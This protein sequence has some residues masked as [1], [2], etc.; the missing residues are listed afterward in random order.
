MRAS[1]PEL[2]PLHTPWYPRV[3]FECHAT[4]RGMKPSENA[5]PESKI[6]VDYAMESLFWPTCNTV[7]ITLETH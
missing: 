2:V 4:C 5:P 7:V 3:I 1:H 6:P